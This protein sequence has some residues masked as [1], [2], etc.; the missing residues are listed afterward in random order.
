MAMLISQEK[1]KAKHM[2]F[3]SKLKNGF[4]LIELL[5]VIAI[6]AILAAML[7][8][9]LSIAKQKALRIACTSNLKQIG[10]GWVMYQSDNNALLPVQWPGVAANNQLDTSSNPDSPWETHEIGRM[11]TSAPYN[12]L[13]TGSGTANGETTSGWWNAGLLW[14]NKYVSE[15]QVLYCPVGAETVGNNMTYAYY[16]DPPQYSVWPNCGAAV[17][18]GDNNPGYIRVAYDYYPQSIIRH[19][20]TA[21][22]GIGPEVALK[23]STVDVTKCIFTDQTQG[24]NDAPH[25]KWGNGMNALFP[26]G[27]V[28]WE[29]QSQNPLE[30]E[31]SDVGK[32]TYS[33]GN[34]SSDSS[35]G[36]S[37]GI[38]IFLFVR[39]NL[40]P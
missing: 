2:L 31:L 40:P 28:K 9:A 13:T 19:T 30:F 8:P 34:S 23:P 32:Q 38:G 10:I 11:V 3:P 20:M 39:A 6:I 25:A 21:P 18:A 27:H 17:A 33:W 22:G 5:V 16:T 24:Y 26:D 37:G 4:T 29:S 36:E 14:A 1:P 35:I 15:G 12:Q 7:L